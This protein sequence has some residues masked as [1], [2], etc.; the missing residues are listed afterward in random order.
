[1]RATLGFARRERP[2]SYANDHAVV[3]GYR[4]PAATGT[5]VVGPM[6]CRRRCLLTEPGKTWQPPRC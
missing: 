6:V 4:L 5:D 3:P 2:D 1:M